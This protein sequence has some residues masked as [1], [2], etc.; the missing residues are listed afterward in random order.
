MTL[1]PV[2]GFLGDE[3]QNLNPWGQYELSSPPFQSTVSADAFS[4][5]GEV[6]LSMS[7]QQIVR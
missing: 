7:Q 1:Q 4:P 2:A 5:V 6:D 3:A